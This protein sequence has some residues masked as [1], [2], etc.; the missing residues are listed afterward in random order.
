[1]VAYLYRRL[2][3][4]VLLLMLGAGGAAAQP[5]PLPAFPGA[6]GYGMFTAGGRGGTVYRV[7]TLADYGVEDEP[8]PGS[9]REALEAEGPRV[10]VFRVAGTIGLARPLA[11][12]NGRLTVA[13][14]TAPGEGVTL[15]NYALDVNGDDVVIRHLRVRPGDVAGIEQD[16][17][18]IRGRNVVLDHVSASWGTDETVS[19]SSGARNVTIQWSLVSE[20]LNRS[21]HHKGAHGYG[22]LLS[23]ADSVTIHHTAYVF[24]ASRNPRPKD[25]LLDFRNNL[26]YGFGG[27][28]GY[29]S[30]DVT[31]MNYVANYLHPLA[32][33]DEGGY[34]FTL[35]GLDS[36]LYVTGNVRGGRDDDPA[37]DWALIRPPDDVTPE[38]AEAVVRV[39]TPFVAPY[40][41]TDDA[42][43]ARNRILAEAGATLPVR[44]AAD[45]RLVALMRRGE[46]RIIDSQEDV[47]GWPVLAEGEAPDDADSD[48]MPDAW[49]RQYGLDA[50]DAGDHRTDADG[51]GYT[52][53]EEYLN[54]T[55]P[56]A[57]WAWMPPPRLAPPAG[58][59]FAEGDTLIVTITPTDVAY[60]VH[61]TLDGT[62]P[63]AASPRY[64]QPFRITA[65][66]HVRARAL[67]D[68][69]HTTDAFAR[70]RRVPWQEAV[71][72][73]RVAPGL[74]YAYYEADDWDEGASVDA[75]EPLA[76][77]V[78]PALDPQL[79]R[80]DAGY[81]L[82]YDGFVR[83][84]SDGVYTFFLHDDARSRLYVDGRFVVRGSSTGN[85]VGHAALRAGLHRLHYRSLHESGTTTPRLEWRGP[86]LPRQ[87]LTSEALVH[88]TGEQ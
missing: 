87:P 20:S 26:I 70:Y 75:M 62:T 44:D 2:G 71:A 6:E 52:N 1:M 76:T 57:P 18:S 11:I 42:E 72:P 82:V 21:V 47:G 39:D 50:A 25:V 22:T 88:A 49:E 30:E 86:G 54:G 27:R 58:T 46:G 81:A 8:I 80:S 38:R 53:I 13:G 67:T 40:V 64:T 60:P 77:G 14:Q 56:H 66:A 16:A 12:E 32:Y 24:H 55:D 61:Y 19:L 43:T 23:D 78:T 7:T 85:D 17:V 48:G 5:H 37:D 45:R 15:K 59:A 51:D 9:L 73:P 84:P 35:G 69:V 29:N 41:R 31:R 63:T 79:R 74:R 83:V 34:A 33:S 68:S 4:L 3:G 36:R 65:S 28:A 10:V